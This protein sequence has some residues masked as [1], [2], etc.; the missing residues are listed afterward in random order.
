LLLFHE[1]PS[2]VLISTTHPERVREIAARHTVEALEIGRTIGG[3]LEIRNRGAL[4]GAW[5]TDELR[6]AY[7]GGLP[8]YV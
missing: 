5:S 8:R 2:R 6:Q 7:E 1:G 4:L 3:R